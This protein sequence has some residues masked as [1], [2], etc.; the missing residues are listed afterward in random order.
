[1]SAVPALASSGGGSHGQSLVMDLAATPL[2]IV[3]L[4]L[5]VAA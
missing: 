3:A 5:F 4:V 1:L 2:G